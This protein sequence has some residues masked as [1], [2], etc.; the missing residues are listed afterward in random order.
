MKF[1]MLVNGL[2][3]ALCQM[4]TLHRY[5]LGGGVDTLKIVL[6]LPLI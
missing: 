4:M 3:E 1:G 6:P 5:F 2:W